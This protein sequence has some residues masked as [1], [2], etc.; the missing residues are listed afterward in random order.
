[1]GAGPGEW[2]PC[3]PPC[4][5]LLGFSL[6]LRVRSELPNEKDHFPSS[7]DLL[8]SAAAMLYS[9][10]CWDDRAQDPEGGRT[11]LKHT[12]PRDD[13]HPVCRPRGCVPVLQE[14]LLLGLS[15][16]LQSL[17]VLPL[18]VS[19]TCGRPGLRLKF[20]MKFH[21]FKSRWGDSKAAFISA[22]KTAPKES[23]W[24]FHSVASVSSV[25]EEG[26]HSLL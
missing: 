8:P 13:A 5:L 22:P 11:N 23:C 17:E 19:C 21:G 1:M 2:W 20:E 12:H 25:W 16:E 18:P 26:T 10:V 6:G 24:G 4:S 3:D 14:W 9:K 15:G 7:H